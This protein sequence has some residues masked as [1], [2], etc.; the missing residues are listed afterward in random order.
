MYRYRDTE[1]NTVSGLLRGTAGTAITTHDAGAIVYNMGRNNLMPE[2]YQNH[3]VSN[4]TYP[5]E[6]GVNLGDGSTTV[7]TASEIDLSNESSI[8]RYDALE[9]FVGGLAQAEHFIGDGITTQF[10]LSGAVTL[11]TPIVTIN[12]AKLLTGYSITTTPTT[13][14][15]T[16]TTAPAFEAV[17]VVSTYTLNAVDPVN[18]TFVTAPADG[19]EITM[20][21]RRGVTWYQQGAGTASNGVPLQETNT[22]P[23]RFLR[24]L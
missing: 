22:A 12:G 14:T 10:A 13:V 20:L 23:A 5:L 9:V 3:V 17:I 6:S 4:I 19:A 8:L 24:G 11:T 7:F 16:F 15:L 1:A 21:V 18:I 2:Q